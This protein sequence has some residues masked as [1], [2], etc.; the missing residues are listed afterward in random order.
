ML[1][2]NA[3]QVLGGAAALLAVLLLVAP[4]PVPRFTPALG[5]TVVWMGVLGTAIAYSLWFTLLAETRAAKLSAYVFLVP[6]VALTASAVIFGERL[7][8]LQ[9]VGVGLVLL[10]IYAIG[11]APDTGGAAESGVPSTPE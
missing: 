8:P 6:V 11:R 9:F 5:I 7:S 10:A 1:E 2:A 4:T 3:F